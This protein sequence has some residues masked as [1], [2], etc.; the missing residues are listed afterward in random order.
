MRFGFLK[1]S[2]VGLMGALSL[3]ANAMAAEGAVKE[4]LHPHWH[5]DGIFGSYDQA[6]LQRGFQVY[7]QV[8]SSCHSMRLVAFR[9][10]AERGAPYYLDR[11]PEGLGIP[12]TTDCSLPTQNPVVKSLAASFQ[13]TDG[14]DDAGD[15]FQRAGLVAD[16]LPSPY[17]NRQQAMAAN[18]GAYPPDMSL[19]VK[20]RHHGASYIYSLL[21]GYA[22]PPAAIDVP[23]GQ[24]YNVYY[25]GD[26]TALVR[27]EYIDDEGHILKDRLK[28]DVD[29][30]YLSEDGVIY[31]GVFK[32]AAPLSE[33]VVTYE[34]GSPETVEQYAK[35]ITAFLTWA[36][37][38]K[39][40]QRKAQ[41]RFVILY[42]VIFATIVYLSYR[43]IWRNVH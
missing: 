43:Q 5:S 26:T 22:E 11:C 33:G 15:M 40:E 30:Y 18:G 16:Y 13:V 20:A 8:C 12:E 36:S 4:Y 27:D 32:M 37:E 25:A 42:L 24:Y 35:D 31:G 10:L 9:H 29:E 14:P 34:D 39:L 38:P 6:Q 19:L 21:Q 17:A 2:F 7:Q 1:S 3:G 28:A 23:A 41:G